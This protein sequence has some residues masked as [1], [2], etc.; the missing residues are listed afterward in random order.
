MI[1][2]EYKFIV[3][4]LP[5]TDYSFAIKQ[6]YYKKEDLLYYL[7]TNL[8]LSD[9]EINSI[10]S[11]RVRTIIN[12]TNK[13]DNEKNTN[14]NLRNSLNK[15]YV[16]NAKSNGL[17]ERLEFEAEIDKKTFEEISKIKK[18][19]SVEKQRFILKI[20][21]YKF[22]FDKYIGKD[23][24]V[25]EVEVESKNDYKKITKIL[26]DKLG[27]KFVDVT[28]DKRYKNENLAKENFYE[29]DFK[30]N[31]MAFYKFGFDWGM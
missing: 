30:L 17:F 6:D 13:S 18:T 15:K 31:W 19:A 26:N 2:R 11:V 20:G 5:K 10:E 28:N 25:L 7:K 22:E 8:N 3:N 29:S 1:E 14:D 27:L 9:E 4:K 24:I 12:N 16:L 23:L 21:K